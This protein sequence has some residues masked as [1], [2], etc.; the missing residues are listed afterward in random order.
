MQDHLRQA[1]IGAAV[2]WNEVRHLETQV[3]AAAAAGCAPRAG[4]N[5][6]QRPA[7]VQPVG[8]PRIPPARAARAHSCCR[9]PGPIGRPSS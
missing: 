8:R 2:L 3:E 1:D 5:R 4:S 6:D 7:C 9:C